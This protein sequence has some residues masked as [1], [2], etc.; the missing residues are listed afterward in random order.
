MEILRS[1]YSRYQKTGT[2][3]RIRTPPE[4]A[5]SV[6]LATRVARTGLHPILI[7]G[8]PRLMH[9]AS[10]LPTIFGRHSIVA[11]TR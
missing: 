5:E 9:I 6:L 7:Q 8:A 10:K 3:F 2:F 11:A 4:L 1:P